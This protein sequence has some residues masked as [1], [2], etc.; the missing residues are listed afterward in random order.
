MAGGSDFPVESENPVLGFYA[1]VTRQDLSGQPPG[2]WRPEERLTRKE[3]LALFTT[4]AA[5]AAFE[6]GRRGLIAEGLD[7]DFT[8]FPRDPMTIPPAE[9]PGL[10]PV[11]T[12]VGGQIVAPSSG[13]P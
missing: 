6:E 7:A 12:I 1:A 4:D 3:A 8:I 2:G 11:F 13:A 10:R 5:W 9:I